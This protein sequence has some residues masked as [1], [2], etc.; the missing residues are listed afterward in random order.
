MADHLRTAPPNDSMLSRELNRRNFLKGATSQ[1]IKH[2]LITTPAV[3]LVLSGAA[4][5][6]KAQTTYICIEDPALIFGDP[7][8]P[9]APPSFFDSFTRSFR[10]LIPRSG[11]CRRSSPTSGGI[12]G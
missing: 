10:I 11:S 1:L 9:T 5:P 3:A 12:R 4:L 7:R 6:A 8:P 2:S